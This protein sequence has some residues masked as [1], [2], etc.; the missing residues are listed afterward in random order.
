VRF[1]V[2]TAASMT[3]RAVFRVIL[4]CRMIVDRRFRVWDFKF[5]RRRVWRSELSSGM[6]CRVKWLSTDVSEV[7]TASIIRDESC[8]HFD[9]T[10][11]LYVIILLVYRPTSGPFSH[12]PSGSTGLSP[13]FRTKQSGCQP[14]NLCYWA[15][16]CSQPPTSALPAPNTLHKPDPD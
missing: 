10:L 11:N 15:T 2:L 6:Y 13:N 7:R 8:N 9:Q 14:L 3:F 16:Q 1:Q 12:A 5:S 4:P